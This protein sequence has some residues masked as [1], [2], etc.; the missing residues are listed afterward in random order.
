MSKS[1]R[2]LSLVAI[3]ALVAGS[4]AAAAPAQAAGE[5]KIEPTSGIGAAVPHQDDISFKVSAT[6]GNDSRELEDLHFLVAND[7]T[8]DV[9]AG[10]ADGDTTTVSRVIDSSADEDDGVVLNPGEFDYSAGDRVSSIT[11]QVQDSSENAFA[12]TASTKRV[13]VTAFVDKNGDNLPNSDE[14]QVTQNVDFMDADAITFDNVLTQ[15]VLGS[16]QTLLTTIS[17]ANINLAQ[18]TLA[19]DLTFG[20]DTVNITSAAT[21]A[22]NNWTYSAVRNDLKVSRSGL[23]ITGASTYAAAV[24]SDATT[25]AI[26]RLGTTSNRVTSATT[27]HSLSGTALRTDVSKAIAADGGTTTVK[28]GSGSFVYTVFVANNVGAALEDEVV[29]LTV[30]EEDNTSLGDGSVTVGSSTLTN[31]SNTAADDMDVTATTGANGKASFTISYSGLAGGSS[32]DSFQFQASVSGVTEPEVTATAA[33][34]SADTVYMA[35]TRAIDEELVVAT[36]AQFTLTYHVLNQFGALYGGS[37]ATVEVTT[38]GQTYTSTVVN[39]VAAVSMPG[40]DADNDG[41]LDMSVDVQTSAGDPSVT[42]IEHD[43]FVGTDDAVAAVTVAADSGSFGTASARISTNSE[44]TARADVRFGTYTTTP[45]AEIG[46]TATITEANGNGTRS[47]VTFSGANLMFEVDTPNSG[48]IFEKGSITVWTDQNGKA[49]VDVSSQTGGNQ[50]L[51]VTA[52]GVSTTK[53]I[54]YGAVD[55]TAGA[56]LTLSAPAYAAP[57]STFQV[58]GTLVDAFGNAVDTAASQLSI[59]YDGPGIAFGTLPTETDANGKFSFAVLLGQNDSGSATVTVKYDQAA[60]GDFTGTLAPDLDITE[61]AT[62]TVGEAPVTQKVNAGSFKGYVAVYARGYE[63]QRLSAKVGNDWVIVDPIVNN[64]GGD[65]HR[66]VEFTGAGV[67]IAVRI[68][69]DRVLVDTIALTT[70]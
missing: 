13:T 18:S 67:D 41:D 29:T 3:V 69:I 34:E 8:F 40:F 63:G 28:A 22:A 24:Y 56:T 68:Y 46:V 42:A 1:R 64:Q 57:G 48:K 61:V 32:A 59:V 4:F 5:L 58:T 10:V 55:A 66:T 30:V 14:W 37:D 33:A 11:L 65:L 2:D 7:G 36:D 43:V 54:Y 50:V 39:G 19:V 16:S 44:A 47:Q 23:N 21:G 62:V 52:G 31:A 17:N 49:D 70:K 12:T 15:P 38:S 26:E 51:T 53:T 27:V 20:D 45:D 9:L 60:D 25:V 6:G 35:D